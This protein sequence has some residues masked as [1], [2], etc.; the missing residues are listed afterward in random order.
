VIFRGH[1]RTL[2]HDEGGFS[3]VELITALSILLIV[4]GSL[5]TLFVSAMRSEV[6]LTQR[7]RVQQ[8]ARLALER[9]RHDIHRACK[10][11]HMDVATGTPVPMPTGA[12]SNMRLTPPLPPPAVGCPVATDLLTAVTWCMELVAANRWKLWRVVGPPLIDLGPPPSCTGDGPE[13]RVEADYITT[14]EAFTL[15]TA[16]GNLAKVKVTFPVDLKPAERSPAY[17][18]EDNLVLRNSER[19]S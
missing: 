19:A 12:Y 9:I 8:E 11:E 3:L 10:A 13:D 7:V 6:D 15:Q 14:S 1:L 5:T 2:A 18:L 17:R 4:V 16:S